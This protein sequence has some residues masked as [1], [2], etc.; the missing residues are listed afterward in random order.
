MYALTEAHTTSVQRT[1]IHWTC[2]LVPDI[3]VSHLPLL[4]YD[5]RI[6]HDV[7]CMKH[8][9]MTNVQREVTVAYN[10]LTAQDDVFSGTTATPTRY[11]TDA[12]HGGQVCVRV[13]AW[14]SASVYA[15]SIGHVQ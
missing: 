15:H 13:G 4:H 2:L 14:V 9:C 7:R 1:G 8:I 6:N 3:C 10:L 12:A 5:Q 11:T